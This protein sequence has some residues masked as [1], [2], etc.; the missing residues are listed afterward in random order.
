MAAS[1]PEWR[2]PEA[3]LD[4]ATLAVAE[5][6]GVVRDELQRRLAPLAG[7]D[8]V[9]FLD[10]PRVDVSST[11]VRERGSRRAAGPL[12]GADEVCRYI[13]Q[14]GLYARQ[15]RHDC[16][17]SRPSRGGPGPAA[18]PVSRRTRGR[19]TSSSWTPRRR[20]LH[21]PVHHLLGQHGPPGEGDP[22]TGSTSA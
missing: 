15:A 16:G 11:M 21:G 17:W 10:I 20:R 3:I 14:Q 1:L 13:A 4:L 8:A 9:V 19:S 7:G 18:S 22:R 6:D 2:E 12:P 5:R